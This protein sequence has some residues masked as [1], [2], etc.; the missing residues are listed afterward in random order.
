MSRRPKAS[1]AQFK[2]TQN[3]TSTSLCLLLLLVLPP[4]W[5]NWVLCLSSQ[6]WSTCHPYNQ[7]AANPNW[8]LRQE[9]KEDSTLEGL[10]GFHVVLR[11]V[12]KEWRG[13]CEDCVMR[14]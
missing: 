7:K 11:G 1:L 4:W 13:N 6:G 2:C 12:E 9:W 8:S 5:V 14:S 3:L 10:T